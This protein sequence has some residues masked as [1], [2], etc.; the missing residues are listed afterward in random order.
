MMKTFRTTVAV[1]LG[2]ALCACASV[3]GEQP[4]K[5]VAV[6]AI[7]AD[8]GVLPATGYVSTGQPD[9]ET[10]R[11]IAEAGYVAVVDLRTAEEPRGFDEAATARELGLSYVSLP[12]GDA[13]DISYKN[14]AALDKALAAFDGPVLLHC[15]SGNRVGALFALSA[16]ARG[17]SDEEALARG[18]AAGLTRSKGVV[19]QRLAEYEP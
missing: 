13:D 14:A 11:I 16:K 5:V 18:D 6:D 3:A 8:A 12:I 1:F 17:A 10:L 15:A 9:A 19:E 7:R 4:V 2:L